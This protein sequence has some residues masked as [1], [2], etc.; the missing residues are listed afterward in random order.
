M[1]YGAPTSSQLGRFKV[2]QSL[3][4]VLCD[5]S[6]LQGAW[7]ERARHLEPFTL[8]SLQESAA[9]DTA[10]ALGRILHR[11]QADDGLVYATHP[12]EQIA[13]YGSAFRTLPSLIAR[14]PPTIAELQTMH[15]Q[16]APGAG[17]GC[18]RE[19]ETYLGFTDAQGQYKVNGQSVSVKRLET[20]LNNLL[21]EAEKYRGLQSVLVVGAFACDLLVVHPFLDGNGRL[22]RLSAQASLVSLGHPGLAFVSFERLFLA[23]RSAYFDAILTT[24]QWRKYKLD[25]EPWALFFAAT[26]LAAYEELFAQLERVT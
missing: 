1:V 7:T 17:A 2:S 21:V 11:T 10:L 25:P 19:V 6:A 22:L 9:T 23:R 4:R 14:F 18:F 24:T 5:I 20:A 13:T 26:V 3:L 16:V 12:P 15:R 8:H